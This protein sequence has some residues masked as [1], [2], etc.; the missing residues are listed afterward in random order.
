MTIPDGQFIIII[1]PTVLM[2]AFIVGEWAVNK[3]RGIE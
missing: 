2:V 3:I 1:A